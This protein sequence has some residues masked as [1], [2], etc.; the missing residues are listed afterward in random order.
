MARVFRLSSFATL[1][2][3]VTLAATFS[4]AQSPVG[5]ITG[6]ITDEQ[7]AAVKDVYVT[8]HGNDQSQRIQTDADGQFRLHGLVAGRY[9][10][11]AARNG[12]TTVV[13]NGVMVKVGKTSTFPLVMKVTDQES[14]PQTT[15]A[16]HTLT[17]RFRGL[18]ATN[19][20][21]G[22]L[23]SYNPVASLPP[24]SVVVAGLGGLQNSR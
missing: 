7:G 3:C 12:Y 23:P 19:S 4:V 5:D 11:T 20:Q 22:T 24:T 1:F 9:V 6:V 14:Q 10:L 8:A 17:A 15:P 13:R 16:P 2:A 18:N 21:D